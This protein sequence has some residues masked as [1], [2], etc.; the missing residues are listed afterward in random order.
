MAWLAELKKRKVFRV[1]AA[2][3]VVGWLLVQVTSIV[4]PALNLPAWTVTFTTVLLLLGFPIALVL[5][6]SFD[7]V[8]DRGATPSSVAGLATGVQPRSIVVLPFANMSDDAAQKHFADGIVEDLTTRLLAL[9]GLKVMSRQSASAYQGRQVD[10]RTISRELGCQYV[11]EGSVRK[12][13]DR[14]RVTAQLIDAPKDEHLWADRY[15]RRLEDAFALQDEICDRIVAA[16]EARLGPGGEPAGRIAGETGAGFEKVE[17]RAR[18]GAVMRQVFR[19]WWTIPGALALVAMAGALTWTL[20]QRGRERWAR[21]EA[22]PQLEALIS[23]DDHVAAFDLATRIQQVIPN[24]PRLK[25]LEP[26]YTAPITLTS[27]PAGATVFFRPYGGTEADWRAIGETPLKD[28]TMPWGVGLW[29]L[30]YPGR[31]TGVFAIRNPGVQLRNVPD[32]AM[33]MRFQATDFTLHLADAATSPAEMVLVH[34]AALY[35]PLVAEE[36]TIDLP[37]FFIDRYEVRNREFKEFI[38]AG[39]YAQAEL[40][41]DLPFGDGVAGWQQAVAKLVDTTGRP[42][43]ATWQ[44]GT[45][46]D[47]MADHP[48]DGVSWFEA[49]AYAR[50]RGKELPTAYH[51]YRAAMSPNERLESLA[52]VMI[53]AGNFAGRGTTPVG[54]RGGI[55]PFGTYDMAGN[56]R[57]WLWN[58]S[59]NGR[60]AA[61]GAWNQAPYVF[62]EL[63]A[64]PPSDRSPG[65][66]F[67]CMRTQHGHAYAAE[68][69]EPIA[70]KSVD[71]AALE[72][73]GDDAYAILAQQLDYSSADLN[74]RV[75]TLQSKNPL[76]TRER[77]TL[78]TG[79]DDSRFA[80]QLFLPTG[81]TPPY[82]AVIYV[83]HAGFTMR[84]VE[85][86]QL[87]PTDSAQP[88]DFILKSGRALIVVALEGSFER[89]WPP[90]RR[91]SM[92]YAERYRVRLRHG[93][94]DV[95]RVIDYLETR[96]DIDAERLGWFGVSWGAQGMT[97]ILAVEPR[98]RSVVLDGGGVFLFEIPDAEQFY[99]YL[100]RITQP[101][102][103]LNGRWDIDV[104]PDAQRRFFELLGTPADQKKH[105]VF[106]AGHGSLPHNHLVRASL[107]WYDKYL[108]PTQPASQRD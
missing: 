92:S 5:A 24:D 25:A 101:V 18:L 48:V 65:N 82:Q 78:N 67:R 76:W 42:G 27:E 95:G 77:I 51:W 63:D 8:R 86:S 14:I 13:D 21:E 11:V 64:S 26:A 97:P 35:V 29:K 41:R 52:T 102:L 28:V 31:A 61:G 59:P 96:Q 39:G 43:P 104:N 83:P 3:A 85:S 81:G 49:V 100:P 87:E 7:I 107:E 79:Y 33:R 34:T 15:D 106:E 23:E 6:W 1:A 80:M 72:P 40:W 4:L 62:N 105:M 57:E 58:V 9:P 94:Q 22:L 2:Y 90:A 91:A 84:R 30:E 36:S 44:A 54:E 32:P 37:P 108:G 75:E 53:A 74:P 56:V 71:F 70:Q 50:F 99:N 103:M 73:V 89:A 17:I 19:T 47:G 60:W 45:Y 55:G 38:D 10:A 69:R 66:G 68:L 93:R 98:F 88:L 46:P 16:I 12:I 20:Q